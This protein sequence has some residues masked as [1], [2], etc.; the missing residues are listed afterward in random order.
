MNIEN[1]L[2]YEKYLEEQGVNKDKP[3]KI[4]WNEIARG[5]YCLT[6]STGTAVDT[7]NV[8]IVGNY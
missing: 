2:S 3:V 5:F 6:C 7:K 4:R 1:K 8:V